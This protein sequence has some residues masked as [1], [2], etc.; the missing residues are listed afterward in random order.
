MKEVQK[1]ITIK[2]IAKLY[3]AFDGAEFQSREECECY[4]M[5]E[6]RKEVLKRIEMNFELSGCPNFDGG[7]NMEYHDYN[8]FRPKNKEEKELL[9]AAYEVS[10]SDELI[11]QW[12][13]IESCDDAAWVSSL[14]YAIGYAQNILKKLGYDLLVGGN[15]VAFISSDNGEAVK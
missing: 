8:W 7:E 4:E 11:G 14:K 13:C 2:Q 12:I 3:V 5:E 6:K 9:E 10:I 15:T 1:E